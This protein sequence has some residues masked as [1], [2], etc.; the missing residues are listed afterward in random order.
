MNPKELQ[1]YNESIRR[2]VENEFTHMAT[3]RG[4]QEVCTLHGCN[5]DLD[6]QSFELRCPCCY[7]ERLNYQRKELPF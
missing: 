1:D 2:Y 5:F 3:F 6:Y 7:E 4:L